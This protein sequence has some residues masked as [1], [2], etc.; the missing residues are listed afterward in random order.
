MLSLDGEVRWF[1]VMV[2][3]GTC[4]DGE[5]RESKVAAIGLVVEGLVN[6]VDLAVPNIQPRLFAA[7]ER[8]PL[9]F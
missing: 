1:E 2:R 7:Y 5:G 4:V 8:L 3:S 9:L 6:V